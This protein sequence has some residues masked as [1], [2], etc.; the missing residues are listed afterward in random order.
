MRWNPNGDGE[1]QNIDEYEL[2]TGHSDMAESY[3]NSV[4]AWDPNNHDGTILRVTKSSIGTFGW[5][6]QQY[7]LEKFKGHRGETV[8]YHTR[9]L[10]VH[11]FVEWFWDNI[12]KKELLK[13]INGNDTYK[14]FKYV[15]DKFP[16]PEEP[17]EFGEIEQINQWVEWQLQRLV[18][19]N[20]NCWEPVGVEAN[21]HA[22]RMVDV[23]GEMIPIHMRGFIDSIFNTGENGFALMELKTGKWNKNKPSA[24][25]KEMQFYRMMLEHSPHHEFLPITHWGWEFPGGG[26]EG[27]DGVEISYE[28]VKTGGRYV[29]SS[30]EKQLQKLVKAHID[31][32]F[33]PNPWLGKLREGESMEAALD[34]KGLKC[35]YC[36]YLEHCPQWSV[37]DE[38][39]DEILEEMEEE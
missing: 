19:T 39:L 7:Y 4:Y 2:E 35:S 20:G 8:Y 31:M 15:M 37:T 17:Y 29:K 12:D 27:G 14:A 25:R 32:D 26:I 10:N 30:V 21:I 16:H 9:G 18:I 28:D 6:P 33:P 24:M 1:R 3:R 23:D 5:C 22:T 34:R 13:L 38:Y 36:D 11:D